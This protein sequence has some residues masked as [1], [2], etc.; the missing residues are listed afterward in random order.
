VV[1]VAPAT[2][3]V[4]TARVVVDVVVSSEHATTRTSTMSSSEGRRDI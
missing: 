1:V 4:D 3:V 2:V